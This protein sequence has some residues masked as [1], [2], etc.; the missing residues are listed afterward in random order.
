M[1]PYSRQHIS[2]D[3]IESVVE[4]LK[5]DLI[6]QGAYL[7]L[8]EDRVKEYC[9]VDYAVAFNSATSAL[10][11]TC[12]AL[13]LKRGDFLWTSPNSFVASANCALYCDASIDFV[14]IDDRTYNI[15]LE[16]LKEKLIESSKLGK[17]PKILVAVHFAGQSCNMKEIY[18]LSKIYGFSVIEDASHAIGGK[19]NN[20]P[21]GS[22]KYSDATIFS[23]H[24]VKIITTAE[25]G[26]IVTNK[27]EIAEKTKLI[28]SHGITREKSKISSKRYGGWYYEQQLLGFNY[29]MNEIQAALGVSQL[30]R[31]DE[32]VIKRHEIR[33]IYDE[34]LNYEFVKIP[35]QDSKTYSSFH[36][37]P[38]RFNLKKLGLNKKELY[39]FFIHNK[40]NVN[41][42]YIPIH[43]QPFYKK[44]GFKYGD[45][46]NSENYY[47][48]AFSLPIFYDLKVHDQNHVIQ[49]IDK[50]RK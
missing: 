31:L 15:S 48:E 22:C 41:V 29:R 4:V 45:F 47:N 16:K 50:L 6:T 25:G 20:F 12:L 39:D 28:R 34:S 18:A 7:T 13:G 30:K 27:D 49:T 32:F 1:I 17:L 42:H 37:Y 11:A 23:F 10:H 46:P 38:V 43:T 9:K 5:S 35:F 2:N 19:Y 26:M 33:K 36:L 21:I 8:F 14:D 3:D 24:P 40:I 44:L